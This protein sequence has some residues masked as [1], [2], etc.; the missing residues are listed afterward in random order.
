MLL[1]RGAST[2]AWLLLAPRARPERGACP[3][4]ARRLLATFAAVKL[5]SGQSASLRGR[6]ETG[7]ARTRQ[8][9]HSCGRAV[10]EARGSGPQRL[11]GQPPE[12]VAAPAQRKGGRRQVR[13][14]TIAQPDARAAR[15]LRRPGCPRRSAAAQTSVA[16][17]ATVV[18]QLQPTQLPPRALATSSG[19]PCSCSALAPRFG[20]RHQDAAAR[21]ASCFSGT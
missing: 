18:L 4:S 8:F 12:G 10:A 3:R 5:T 6:Q 14:K 20:A 11:C 2:A 19:Q 17:T 7:L 15:R 16:G 21:P 1:R 9:H 13:S